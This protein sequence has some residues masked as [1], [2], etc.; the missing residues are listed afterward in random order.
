MADLNTVVD[1]L[2][3]DD[4]ELPPSNAK[5]EQQACDVLRVRDGRVIGG[6]SYFDLNTVS[7][8]IAGEA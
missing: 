3:G 1:A 4:G 6:R 7:S 8:Q 2:L 5:V